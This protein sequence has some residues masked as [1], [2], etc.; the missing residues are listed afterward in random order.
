MDKEEQLLQD[1]VSMLIE[2]KS[3]AL[4]NIFKQMKT[5][6]VGDL[7]DSLYGNALG[8]DLLVFLVFTIV[9]CHKDCDYST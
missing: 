1:G 7:D 3:G 6:K 4:Q 8:S 9:N 5:G 2:N